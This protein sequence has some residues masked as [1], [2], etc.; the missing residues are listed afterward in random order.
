[1]LRI[2]EG[3]MPSLPWLGF[4]PTF[5]P[6]EH[7]VQPLPDF[8]D[9]EQKIGV[10]KFLQAI[11][12]F[13]NEAVPLSAIRERFQRMGIDAPE[14]IDPDDS[15]FQRAIQYA[16]DRKILRAIRTMDGLELRTDL[17]LKVRNVSDEDAAPVAEI[18]PGDW[19][20]RA[21]R[22]DRNY[23]SPFG[24]CAFITFEEDGIDLDPHNGII[25][26]KIGPSY[27]EAKVS[28]NW[29][30]DWGGVKLAHWRIHDEKMYRSQMMHDKNGDARPYEHFWISGGSGG[31][32]VMAADLPY[33][34]E[35]WREFFTAPY[36]F[37][38]DYIIQG[39]PVTFLGFI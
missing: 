10:L 20:P 16:L 11:Q 18:A 15:I 17:Y 5:A 23:E 26:I 2:W 27:A 31:V 7:D 34:I 38:F 13:K 29:Q 36:R 22:L 21:R 8:T 33:W 12:F 19:C 14:M 3:A 6:T 1:M 24:L 32:T 39:N 25:I 30:S 35:K 4:Q 37:Q 28:L 9:A